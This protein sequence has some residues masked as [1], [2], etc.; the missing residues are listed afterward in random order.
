MPF[1]EY[2]VV[3]APEK[4][5]RIKGLKGTPRFASGLEAL[6]N[7]LAQDGWEYYRAE[8]LPEEERKGFLGGRETVMRNILIF[9]R[10]LTFEETAEPEPPPRLTLSQP[11]GPRAPVRATWHEDDERT[12]PVHDGGEAEPADRTPV[13]RRPLVAERKSGGSED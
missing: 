7:D 8:S 13:F 2:K 6:M 1:Y 11:T 5:Q 9:R 10:E 3:P 4:S 12:D